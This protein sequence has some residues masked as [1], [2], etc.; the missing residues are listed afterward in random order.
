ME[1]ATSDDLHDFTKFSHFLLSTVFKKYLVKSTY[2]LFE[3]V[4]SIHT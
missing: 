2:I 1:L 4:F 3:K